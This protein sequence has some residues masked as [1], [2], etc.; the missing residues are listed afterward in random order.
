MY[1]R[2]LED[3]IKISI[4]PIGYEAECV[5][6]TNNLVCENANINTHFQKMSAYPNIDYVPSIDPYSFRSSNAS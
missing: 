5:K 3:E 2:L 6:K 1:A 4:N